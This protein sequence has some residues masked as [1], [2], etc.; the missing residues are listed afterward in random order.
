[1]ERVEGS[2]DYLAISNYVLPRSRHSEQGLIVLVVKF[3]LCDV[4]HYAIAERDR[5]PN[6][7]FISWTEPHGRREVDTFTISDHV[8]VVVFLVFSRL[9]PFT[10][11]SVSHCPT[12]TS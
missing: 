5:R 3:A 8:V 11:P 7:R 6:F 1:M 2:I 12:S 4:L 9:P 10:Y